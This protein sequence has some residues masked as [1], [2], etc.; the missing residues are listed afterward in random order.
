MSIRTKL[1][2]GALS[3]EQRRAAKWGFFMF[4]AC[5]V[6]A[7]ASMIALFGYIVWST[8]QTNGTIVATWCG[9]TFIATAIGFSLVTSRLQRVMGRS[10]SATTDAS[11]P[12]DAI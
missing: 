10:Q 7:V 1:D 5:M 2:F 4:V 8:P 11:P 6:G 12:Q 9:A 3:D